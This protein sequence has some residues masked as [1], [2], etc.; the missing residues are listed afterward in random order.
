[1][2]SLRVRHLSL[3]YGLSPALRNLH[4]DVEEGE[5]LALVGPNGA[6]KSS[7]IRALSGVVPV[8]EGTVHLGEEDLLSL[9]PRE[10]ALRVAVVPQAA[11]LPST[12]TAG[13][14]VLMGRTPH[15]GHWGSAGSC[16]CD[17][18]W[19]AMCR[20][21]VEHLAERRL[22]DLSG[23]EHQRV[24]IARALAQEPRVLLLDEP[25]AHL[26]LKHQVAL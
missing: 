16:D 5:V 13:E 2:P 14:I 23:G 26:D 18:A 7:L 3:A 11:R 10:R 25:T 1:M 12:F 19:E 22:E 8:T 9:A 21:G 6:G 24:V 4:L 15:L 20:A 17:V